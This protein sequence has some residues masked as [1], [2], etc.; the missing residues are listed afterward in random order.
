ML[1][2]IFCEKQDKE[3]AN[4][5]VTPVKME[6]VDFSG[7]VPEGYRYNYTLE[8]DLS[9]DGYKDAIIVASKIEENGISNII[10]F[11]ILLNDKSGSYQ[12]LTKAEMGIYPNIYSCGPEMEENLLII[13]CEETRSFHSFTFG[14]R[15]GQIYLLKRS[16]NGH[17]FAT[18]YSSETDYITGKRSRSEGCISNDAGYYIDSSCVEFKE[19]SNFEPAQFRKFEDLEQIIYPG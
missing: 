10:S 8:G 14:F 5:S 1:A 18:T 7:F 9:S 19:E 16:S 2:L 17:N 13:S 15:D 12:L 11:Y 4:N 3:S 6:T